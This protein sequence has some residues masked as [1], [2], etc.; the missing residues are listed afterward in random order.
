[1]ADLDDPALTDRIVGLK[2]T[3]DQAQADALQAQAM[4]E[5]SA[6]HAVTPQM[7]RQLAQSARNWMRVDGGGYRRDHL[8]LLA[9]RVEVADKEVRITGSKRNLLRTLVA[10]SSSGVKSD[11][12]GVPSFVPKWRTTVH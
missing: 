1:V 5:S 7:L 12:L 4:L 6:H 8:R 9:P 2:A 3:R 11:T 10:I